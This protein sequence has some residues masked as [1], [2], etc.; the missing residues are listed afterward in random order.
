MMPSAVIGQK[1]TNEN[2]PKKL[3]S[4]LPPFIWTKS[5]RTAV[6]LRRASQSKYMPVCTFVFLLMLTM[7]TVRKHRLSKG[8]EG[9]RRRYIA[10]DFVLFFHCLP[11]RTAPLLLKQQMLLL[12]M[13]VSTIQSL[14]NAMK[15]HIVNLFIVY[16]YSCEEC[17]VDIVF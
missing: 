12:K 1:C 8:K 15:S 5:K 17:Q 9:L 10:H 16:L 6:F 7:S 2:L 11:F 13:S 4:A 14:M 3:G